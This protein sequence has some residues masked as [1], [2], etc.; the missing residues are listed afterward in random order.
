MARSQ[1][2]T[3]FVASGFD[4]MTRGC[5]GKG[6]W[7]KGRAGSLPQSSTLQCP[8]VLSQ[9]SQRDVKNY[10]GDSQLN[11]VATGFSHLGH[12]AIGFVSERK[13]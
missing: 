13:W 9:V 5:F 1:G 4:R 11:K 3:G 6:G 8:L 12:L 7:G 10:D 2:K